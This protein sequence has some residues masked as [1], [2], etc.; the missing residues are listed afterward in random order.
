M[1]PATKLINR[2]VARAMRRQMQ[3]AQRAGKQ[4]AQQLLNTG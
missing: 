2:R 3:D 4:S 1:K